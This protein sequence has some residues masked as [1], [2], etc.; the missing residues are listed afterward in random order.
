MLATLGRSDERDSRP[1]TNAPDDVSAQLREELEAQAEHHRRLVQEL[2]GAQEAERARMAR[3]IHDDAIQVLAAVGVR[4]DMSVER[5]SDPA[6]QDVM[7]KA[8]QSVRDAIDRLRLLVFELEPP[9]LEREGL[10]GA[11]VLYLRRLGE[12]EER[13]WE[14]ENALREEPP[15]GIRPV[16]Y[17][18]AQ[19]AISNVRRHSGA[20]HASIRFEHSDD[21]L[22]VTIH[23]DGDGFDPSDADPVALGRRGLASMRERAAAVGGLSEI[24]SLP[25]RGTTVRFWLPT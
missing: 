17:R 11:I 15:A 1:G 16:A 22:L 9:A 19:Q 12:T 23:D 21:G 6:E 7:R 20:R 25:E 24:D 3:A 18:I 14:V 8:A 5:L 2:V 10:V 4:C 13:R